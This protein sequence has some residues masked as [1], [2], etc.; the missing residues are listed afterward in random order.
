MS[1]EGIFRIRV[2]NAILKPF[3]E[4]VIGKASSTGFPDMLV[5]LPN[6][7]VLLI[8]LKVNKTRYG[9][10]GSQKYI[11]SLFKRLDHNVL[12]LS[13]HEVEWQQKLYRAID[14]LYS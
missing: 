13:E 3:P 1:K 6:E 9:E 11:F 8:E 14:T 2:K 12:L 4:A 5:F 10:Q 7:K